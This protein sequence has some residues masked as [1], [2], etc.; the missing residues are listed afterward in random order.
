MSIESMFPPSRSRSKWA[1]AL[2]A[3]LPCYMLRLFVTFV[4]VPAAVP[5]AGL[6]ILNHGSFTGMATTVLEQAAGSGTNPD[7][8]RLRTCTD[9]AARHEP[10]AAICLHWRTD[11]VPI[12]TLAPQI[13]HGLFVAW[14]V[15]VAIVLTADL[16]WSPPSPLALRRRLDSI[17]RQRA[18]RSRASREGEVR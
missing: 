1:Q 7:T 3:S 12:A 17:G 6:A 11:D 18:E 15:A 9:T 4:I 2:R 10:S 14:L 5:V 8:I 13:G 16:A